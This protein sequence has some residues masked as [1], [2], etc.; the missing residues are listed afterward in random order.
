[1]WM[2]AMAILFTLISLGCAVA[3]LL[4]SAL[5]F[6]ITIAGFVSAVIALIFETVAWGHWADKIADKNGYNY[7]WGFYLAL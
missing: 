5:G 3:V 6:P 7:K 1:M 4:L 2:L